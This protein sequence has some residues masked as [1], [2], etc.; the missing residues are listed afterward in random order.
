MN[1]VPITHVC[2]G[3]H[4]FDH[5]I[6]I[7]GQR[8]GELRCAV[9]NSNVFSCALEV[10]GAGT[11][12]GAAAAAA[13]AAGVAPEVGQRSRRPPLVCRSLLLFGVGLTLSPPFCQT[14]GNLLTHWQ[15]SI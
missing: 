10:E 12:A 14:I 3:N 8:L 15:T 6:E 7:L 1:A 13:V 11:A 4:E 5:S 2:L 9:I